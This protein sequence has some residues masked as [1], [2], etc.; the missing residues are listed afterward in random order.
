[1]DDN[2]RSFLIFVIT[3]SATLAV[4]LGSLL[5]GAKAMSLAEFM[6]A[7]TSEDAGVD[8][9]ILWSVRMPRSLVAFFAGAGLAVSGYLMQVVTRNPLA[10][11]ELTGATAGAIAVIVPAYIY[12]PAIS[13]MSYPLLGAVGALAASGL[14]L[15]LSQGGRASPWHLALAGF[16]VALFLSALTTYLL[17]RGGPP[18]PSVLFWLSG[19]FQGRSWT[20][21]LHMLPCV[22]IG[23]LGALAASRMIGLIAL[24]DA[25]AM[26]MG[27]RLGLWKFALLICAILPIAGIAPVAGAV[28]FIGLATPHLVRML[29]PAGPRWSILF[30]V[31]CGGLI[32]CLADAIARS[33]AAPREIPVGVFT[34]ALGGPVIVWYLRRRVADT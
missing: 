31:A 27:A 14:T 6:T 5:F 18:S 9:I 17:L 15:V 7:L 29:R 1:M 2:R 20:H 3:L 13:S 25:A 28:T 8:G 23:V 30:N 24:G 32:A 19:G 21:L 4:M 34:A 33:A 10:S 11:P 12:F 26:S 16:S 22:L